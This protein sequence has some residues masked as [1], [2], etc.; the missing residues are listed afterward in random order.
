MQSCF[1]KRVCV[2]ISSFADQVQIDEWET[3]ISIVVPE[4]QW[5]SL[6][7]ETN[8]HH[9]NQSSSVWTE[10]MALWKTVIA[11]GLQEVLDTIDDI[12]HHQVP[13]LNAH[14]SL[15]P[16]VHTLGARW[17]ACKQRH[18]PTRI[19]WPTAIHK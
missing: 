3:C 17:K 2:H 14:P 7:N 11:P 1:S 6:N 8:E 19:V 15:I 10:Y 9:E 12:C 4:T 16:L 5:I 13:V 18:T